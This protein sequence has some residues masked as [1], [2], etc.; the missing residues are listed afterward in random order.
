MAQP[1]CGRC[2]RV[3]NIC[4]GGGTRRFKFQQYEPDSQ[5]TA[6]PSKSL[7]NETTKLAAEFVSLMEVDDV[8]YGLGKYGPYFFIELPSRLGSHPAMDATTSALTTSFKSIRLR[9]TCDINV[10]NLYGK[11]LRTLQ[12]CL[13]DPEQPVVLKLELV[14]MTM[15]C[16]V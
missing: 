6:T 1:K 9:K 13:S 8:R 16:Q 3:G 12:D 11:A 15:L 5:V 4:A 14:L 10:L 7:D 2:A